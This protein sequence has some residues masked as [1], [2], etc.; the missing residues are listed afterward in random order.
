M[1]SA[2]NNLPIWESRAAKK[3]VRFGNRWLE[4][5]QVQ[6]FK[7]K[8]AGLVEEAI[9]LVESK[10]ADKA[11]NKLSDASREDPESLQ[12][13]FLSGLICVFGHRDLQSA[14]QAFH[15]CVRRQPNHVPSLN[16][17]ALVEVRLQRYS[18]AMAHWK[19]ALERLS[20]EEISQNIGRLVELS[21]TRACPCRLL[22]CRSLAS[23]SESLSAQAS[24]A[25]NPHVGWLY[26]PFTSYKGE[27]PWIVP[28]K[29]MGG[30]GEENTSYGSAKT[31][32]ACT[33]AA[34]EQSSV[35]TSSARGARCRREQ[36]ATCG[37]HERARP[38]LLL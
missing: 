22:L 15:E 25:Y 19:T 16:N 10:Q 5:E 11:R 14:K 38:D 28:D 32:C 12:A 2:K 4:P 8:A 9:Q 31:G 18:D 34:W 27:N 1:L 29:D 20:A 17:L 36:R 37:W 13:N 26:M 35:P 23:C 3:M 24:G 30:G 21:K 7:E 6:E 33:A